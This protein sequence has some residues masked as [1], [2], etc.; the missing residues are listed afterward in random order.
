MMNLSDIKVFYTT[1]DDGIHLLC[2]VCKWETL[3]GLGA[4]LDSVLEAGRGG[5][6]WK[7]HSKEWM[8][9]GEEE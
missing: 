9:T 8:L 7:E 4:N 2:N 6:H 3:V 1:D 5:E